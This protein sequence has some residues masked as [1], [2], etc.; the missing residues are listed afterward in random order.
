MLLRGR[1]ASGHGRWQILGMVALPRNK[2]CDELLPVDRAL[3]W[4]RWLVVQGAAPGTGEPQAELNVSNAMAPGVAQ[5]LRQGR[6]V[7]AEHVSVD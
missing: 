4:F 1:V 5:D 7:P 6:Q 2:S 3:G